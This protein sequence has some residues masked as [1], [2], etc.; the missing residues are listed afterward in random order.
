[1]KA[2]QKNLRIFDIE[3]INDDD[4]FTYMNKNM[5]LLKDFFLLIDGHISNAV[6]DYLDEKGFCYKLKKDCH[7]KIPTKHSSGEKRAIIDQQAPNQSVSSAQRVEIVKEPV[8]TLVIH[9]PVRSG[10]EITHEGDVTIFGRV[11]SAAKVMAEGNVEVYG[12]IDGLIQCDG[13]YMIVKELGKG[14]I[15]FNG[16]ILDR[17][18][19][20]GNLKKITYGKEGV[21]VKDLFETT[22][23]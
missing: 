12:I 11:N 2:K 7:I 3:V 16:D 21:V 4:F 22:H 1:M 6:I 10:V 20:D 19:F 15:V 5:I 14:H 18:L 23:Y 9:Q 13:E 17:E 8:K